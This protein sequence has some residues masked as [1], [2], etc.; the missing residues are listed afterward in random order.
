MKGLSANRLKPAK[1]AQLAAPPV[2]VD[3]RATFEEFC[4][5]HGEPVHHGG[6]LI[7]ADGWAHAADDWKGPAWPPPAAAD[8]RQRLIRAYWTARLGIVKRLRQAA[9]INLD[10][11]ARAC[12]LRG[13]GAPLMQA[14]V[15]WGERGADGQQ[16]AVRETGL[17]G[18][19]LEGLEI[20]LTALRA[21]E[22]E[23]KTILEGLR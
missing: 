4:R 18:D 11:I 7:F 20:R 15:T 9:E 6:R 3:W 23:C 8:E 16:T 17:I 21:A 5:L 12:R 14:V 10:D 1:V 19:A 2:A 22:A 13:A